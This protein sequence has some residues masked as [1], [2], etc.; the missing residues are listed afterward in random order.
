MKRIVVMF[1]LALLVATVGCKS[2]EKS[3]AAAKPEAAAPSTATI[4]LTA[5]GSEL[6]PPVTPDKIPAGGWYCDM[7]TVHYARAEKGD[8]KCPLCHMDLKEKK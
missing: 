1:G 8:G 2:E 3:E 5:E 7:G 6:K 4:A